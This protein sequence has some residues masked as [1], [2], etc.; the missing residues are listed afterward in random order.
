MGVVPLLRDRWTCSPYAVAAAESVRAAL[1]VTP[2]TAA[3]LV[4]RGYDTPE[5]ARR[6]LAADESHDPFAL[7]A[8]AEACARILDHVRRGSSI[9]VHGDYDVDGVC[10]TA[11]MVRALRGLG[12][13][14]RWHLPSRFDEGYGVSPRTIDRLADEGT[15]LLVTVDCGITAVAEVERAGARGLDVVVTDHH[16]PAAALPACPVVHPGLGAYPFPSLCG[17]GV[18]HQLARAL[19]VT[20]G[21]DA[22]EADVDLDLVALATVADVV[23]LVGE[24]RRLVRAGLRALARTGKPGLR[25][26]MAVA[27]VEPGR[28]DAHAL[29]FRLGPRLNAAGRIQRADAALEL[30]LTEDGA[31][32]QRIAEELDALNRER[33]ETETRI[34]WA[35]ES[36][37]AE[38]AGAPALVLAGRDW[39]PGVIGIVASRMV[40]RHGR[41]CVLVALE[42]GGGRGSGRS[43]P[44]Y[45]LHAA[46]AACAGHLT[47]FGGHA[48]AAGLEIE[49]EKVG[50][51]RAALAA[52]AGARLGP[53]DLRPAVAVDALVGAGALGLPLVEDLE[54][55]G[56]FGHGN[57]RP[58]LLV[59][60]ARVEDVR[61]L[62]T[63]GQHASLTVASGGAR[64]RVMAFRTDSTALGRAGTE[65]CD[66]VVELERSEWRNAIEPLAVL[67][68]ACPTEP[69]PIE[70][71]GEQPFW[72]A[73]DAALA[74]APEG[75]TPPPASLF[76]ATPA[77]HAL[78]PP[79]AGAE[80]AAAPAGHALAGAG[81]VVAP[82]RTLAP[83]TLVPQTPRTVLD[84][85]G[86]GIA[87]VAGDLLSSGE[88]VLVVCADVSRR[89]AGLERLLGGLAARAPAPAAL[90]SWC[91]LAHEP[92]LARDFD[93]LLAVDPPDR[94]ADEHL[95]ARAPAPPAGGWAHRAW[96]DPERAFALRMAEARWHVE[97][98][99]RDL[100]GALAARPG[101][102]AGG[103]E[104]RRLLEGPG[105]HGLGPRR[106]ARLVR[107]LGELGL[108]TYEPESPA[109]ATLRVVDGA[110][111][112]LDRSPT[113]RRS[114]ERLAAA[115]TYLGGGAS[116]A[117]R[118]ATAPAAA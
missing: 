94:V 108:A 59:P 82:R 90:V 86:E 66:V 56:P 110:R 98:P 30:L 14:P 32:A 93:H 50:A 115:R 43:V 27:Q 9:V 11:L 84:R 111:T 18:A 20:G 3:V 22:S 4:R 6:F 48:Q 29:G 87:G 109:G 61:A 34:L 47:R 89:R 73:L 40:E 23:P 118:T 25:A 21:R 35:A 38:H 96:A 81:P 101:R 64:A 60:A 62:G 75:G 74:E 33:R 91:A 63:E 100:Y 8:M 13:T 88:R 16:R 51:F 57:P 71:V 24:N 52:H 92:A 112:S 116:E 70:V 46:L 113:Y 37:A 97:A 55:L 36:A 39:H 76:E 54:R 49:T 1:G 2:T 106:A 17:T 68:A 12:A 31:R 77:G 5:A 58:S 67:R 53:E 19:L 42:E 107:I 41:P 78:A 28:V 45:D 26:L 104:L 105:P 102:R 44:A 99:L 10:A 72:A 103:I 95:L 15:G 85:R 69:G 114:R 65:S 80:P 117:A 79:L 7:P 83:A